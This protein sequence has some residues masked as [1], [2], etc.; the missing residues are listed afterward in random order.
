MHGKSPVWKQYLNSWGV[1]DAP[2]DYLAKKDRL[3]VL[4]LDL[5]DDPPLP[6]LRSDLAWVWRLVLAAGAVYLVIR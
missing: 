1:Q 3:I 6:G 4:R 5:C 2:E